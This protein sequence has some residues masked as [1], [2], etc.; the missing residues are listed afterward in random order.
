[1]CC[2]EIELMQREAEVKFK[3][4]GKFRPNKNVLDERFKTILLTSA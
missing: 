1:M 2:E 3:L 4:N